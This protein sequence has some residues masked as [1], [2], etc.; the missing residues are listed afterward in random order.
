MWCL[1][2]GYRLFSVIQQRSTISNEI[3]IPNAGD[4]YPC[5]LDNIQAFLE[6]LGL[7]LWILCRHQ[8]LNRDL[9]A[10]QWLEE[11]S[12]GSIMLARREYVKRNGSYLSWL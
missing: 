7:G 5:S 3:E 10:F 4:P 11:L 9:A 1:S 12:Y 6:G 2:E 8:K